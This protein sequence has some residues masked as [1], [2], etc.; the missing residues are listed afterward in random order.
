[1]RRG[2]NPAEYA[3]T[4]AIERYGIERVSKAIALAEQ[5]ATYHAVGDVLGI[6]RQGAD[7]F[8]SRIGVRTTTYQ[9]HPE[10]VAIAA[11]EEG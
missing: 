8:L 9:I 10:V 4:L 6:T 2:L 11:E 1:M 7:E 3:V 5:G